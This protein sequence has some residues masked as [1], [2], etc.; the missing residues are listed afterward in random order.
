M[1]APQRDMHVVVG[2][3]VQSQCTYQSPV[4]LKRVWAANRA[5]VLHV[6]AYDSMQNISLFFPY[7]GSV[8]ADK[9]VGL[10]IMA[11]LPELSAR[12]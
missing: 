12:V 8:R 7:I 11:L 10:G 9:H 5:N 3:C 4:V 6:L 2:L 1:A